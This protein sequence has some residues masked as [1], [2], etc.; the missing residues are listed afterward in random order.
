M[1]NNHPVEISCLTKY[2][3]DLQAVDGLSLVVKTGEVHGLLGPNGAGK[4]SV[5]KCL[6]GITPPS[7][8]SV[9]IYGSRL[10]NLSDPALVVG[11]VMENGLDNHMTVGRHLRAAA[12]GSGAGGWLWRRDATGLRPSRGVRVKWPGKA[13]SG[14]VVHRA[15]PPPLASNCLDRRSK[16][17]DSR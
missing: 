10:L 12:V 9:L 16:S 17:I 5:L 13:A 14:E 2:Y 8:G 3:G 6:L 11:V 4:T 1:R 15:A 7:S